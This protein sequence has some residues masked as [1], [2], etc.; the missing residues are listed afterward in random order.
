[1]VELATTLLEQPTLMGSALETAGLLPP[2]GAETPYLDGYAAAQAAARRAKL[3][4]KR[5]ATPT[6][7]LNG[8]PGAG[9]PPAGS[10][11]EALAALAAAVRGMRATGGGGASVGAAAAGGAG[12][13]GSSGG[14]GGGSGGE[15]TGGSSSSA[16]ADGGAVPAAGDGEAD[17]PTATAGEAVAVV[18]LRRASKMGD[19]EASYHL[20]WMFQHGLGVPK[21]QGRADKLIARW[22]SRGRAGG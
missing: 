3:R 5:P 17:V 16:G 4:A 11:E 14:G 22:D 10:P 15:G 6:S 20:A 13:G 7:L 18:W 21:D 1:M 9:G 8:G 12:A 2:R 19:S